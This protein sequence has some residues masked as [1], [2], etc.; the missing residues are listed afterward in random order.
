MSHKANYFKIGLFSSITLALLIGF[1]ILLGA[2]SWFTTSD[3]AE[4]YF[5]ESVQGL[6]IGSPVKFRGVTIGKVEEIDIASDVYGTGGIAPNEK[7]LRY[8]YVKFSLSPN[9]R[10]EGSSGEALKS[11]KQY[12]TQ[13]LRI[14]LATSDLVGNVYLEI[15]F[16]NPDKN[17][18]LPINWTPENIYIPSAKSTLSRFTDNIDSLFSGLGHIDYKTVVEHF[19][20]L[21]TLSTKTLNDANVKVLGAQLD[22]TLKQVG[23]LSQN[24]NEIISGN[25]SKELMSSLSGDS[26]LL[27]T[28]LTDTSAAMKQL[29]A[30]LSRANELTAS[31]QSN[32]IGTLTELREASNNLETVTDTLKNNPSSLIFA[33]SAEPVEPGK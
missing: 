16:M 10:K 9:I 12:I 32:I 26:K 11:L 14:S 17:P 23:D 21:V 7:D 20:E 33:K 27:E 24:M 3:H 8:I 29:N 19:D 31:Q 22:Q 13:G 6:E 15:N 25:Q 1:L 5:N 4:T 2:S 18:I 30:L 28:T